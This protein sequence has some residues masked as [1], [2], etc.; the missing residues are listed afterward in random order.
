VEAS[1]RVA[2]QI[3]IYRDTDQYGQES[4]NPMGDYNVYRFKGM[5][6]M[7]MGDVNTQW[8]LGLVNIDH[9]KSYVVLK[10]VLNRFLGH[11]L[12]T[13]GVVGFWGVPVDE[14]FVVMTPQMSNGEAIFL[15]WQNQAILTQEGRKELDP[16]TQV[17]RLDSSLSGRSLDMKKE[18]LISFLSTHT[19]YLSHQGLHFKIKEQIYIMSQ[20]L[21]GVI[22]PLE[23][24][25]GRSNLSLS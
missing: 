22:Y 7:V 18:Q 6:M 15:D 16:L 5:A 14:G 2:R 9:E 12:A 21:Q 11:A 10:Q 3:G 20:E 1:A 17:L 4:F 24:F 25:Q 19:T 23:N 13:F 8:H